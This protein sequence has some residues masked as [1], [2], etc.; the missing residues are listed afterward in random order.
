MHYVDMDKRM[1]EWVNEAAC[2]IREPAVESPPKKRRPGRPRAQAAPE[3]APP[4]AVPPPPPSGGTEVVM[5]EEDFDLRHHKQLTAQ[6]NFD[7]VMFDSWKIKPWCACPSL[8]PRCL[9]GMTC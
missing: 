5:T 4:A 6:R 3:P 2:T 7:M 1:D 8:G 9:R